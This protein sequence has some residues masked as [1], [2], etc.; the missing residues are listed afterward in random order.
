MCITNFLV[1][2]TVE[3]VYFFL[4]KKPTVRLQVFFPKKYSVFI[5]REK[6]L[7]VFCHYLVTWEK[8]S[9]VSWR[10]KVF[11]SLADSK[12]QRIGF[13]S[14]FLIFKGIQHHEKMAKLLDWH[15]LGAKRRPHSSLHT[16]T[17]PLQGDF[18]KKKIPV[19]FFEM[20]TLKAW[21][22]RVE[23]M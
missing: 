7:N 16:G 1:V 13:F 9:N 23:T 4:I 6:K 17:C 15:G 21:I 18:V 19:S 10:I 14:P 22:N 20:L 3:Q 2:F 5:R 12:K 8:Y 11:H